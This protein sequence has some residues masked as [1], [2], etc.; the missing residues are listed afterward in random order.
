M[1]LMM[2]KM[3]PMILLGIDDGI[4]DNCDNDDNDDHDDD[5]DNDTD[6]SNDDDDDYV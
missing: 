6:D 5:G 4:G 3:I 2:V 1:I